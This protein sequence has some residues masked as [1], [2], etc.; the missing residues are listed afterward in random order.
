MSRHLDSST[1]TLPKSWSSMED[2]V[3]PLERNLYGHPLAGLLWERQFAKSLVL[4]VCDEMTLF[5]NA[6]Q[7]QTSGLTACADP[8]TQ[9][10]KC[11]C[12]PAGG[13]QKPRHR[14]AGRR[15]DGT[16]MTPAHRGRAASGQSSCS[17]SNSLQFPPAAHSGLP[18]GAPVRHPNAAEPQPT[19]AKYRETARQ[20]AAKTDPACRGRVASGQ[21]S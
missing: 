18:K 6:A 7:R 17:F 2:P 15:K 11:S 8:F 9:V 21:G 3:V 19:V 1:K 12:A 13:R 14:E 10:C 16:T 5:L 4:T 20:A